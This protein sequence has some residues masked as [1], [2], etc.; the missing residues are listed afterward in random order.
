[1]FYRAKGGITYVARVNRLGETRLAR[2]CLYCMIG[3]TAAQISTVVYTDNDGGY[4]IE[5]LY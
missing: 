1:M 4:K 2:P 3:L 5:K